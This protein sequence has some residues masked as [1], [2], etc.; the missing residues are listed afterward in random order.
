MNW[1]T[2]SCLTTAVLIGVPAALLAQ[3]L[4]LPLEFRQADILINLQSQRGVP[5]STVTNVPPGSDGRMP[6]ANES[7]SGLQPT[8]N[9]FQGFLS[10]GGVPGLTSNIWSTLNNNDALRNGTGPFS[11]TLARAM[12]LPIGTSNNVATGAVAIIIRHVRIG[13]PYLNRQISLPFGAI[14][15][16]PLTDARGVSITI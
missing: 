7:N 2:R 13:A 3:P 11:G 4:S 14:V 9:Q 12:G 15:V 10:L 8:T 1:L 5:I 16:A 6:T